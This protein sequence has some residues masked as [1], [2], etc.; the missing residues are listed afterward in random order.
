[1]LDRLKNAFRPSKQETHDERI[2][3]ITELIPKVLPPLGDIMESSPLIIFP[4]SK[5][6]L[7]KDDMQLA[8]K[9]A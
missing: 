3:R 7:P 8:L 4:L 9:V 1:M 2:S 5:L 6:P